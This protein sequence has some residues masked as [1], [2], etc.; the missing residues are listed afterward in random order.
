MKSLFN[1]FLTIFVSLACGLAIGYFLFQSPMELSSS[2]E[3]DKIPLYWVAPMDANFRRDKPGKSPM[4]MDLVPVYETVGGPGEVVISPEVVNNLGVRTVTVLNTNLQ[5]Q[6]KTVGYVQYDQDKL[7][8]IHPRVEGWV[9]KLY[10]K[11][12]G[13]PVQKN[14]PLYDLYS[15]ELVNAQEE[16]LLAL[17][18]NN[19]Q[20]IQSA[21]LRLKALHIPD[22]V[23]THINKTRKV[24]QTVTFYAP[25]AGYSDNLKIREG[26][27]VTPGT[28]L[29]SI[30]NL[31]NV[32][33]EAE[34]FERQAAQVKVGLA[35]TMTLDYLPGR[36]WVGAVDYVYPA[37]NPQNRT[38]RVRLRFDNAEKILKPNMFAQ[39]IIHAE[40]NDMKLVVPNEAVIRT[41]SQ[42]RVVLA[43]EQGRFKS[44]AVKLGASDDVHTQVLEGLQQGDVIVSSAQFL[45]D[46][47]SSKTSDFMR[48][49]SHTE[50][51]ASV[52][53]EAR[54]EEVMVDMGMV[55]LT[56]QPIEEWDWPVMTMMFPVNDSVDIGKLKEGLTLHVE[57]SETD[58]TWVLS[59]IHSMEEMKHD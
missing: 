31:E 12:S 35:V 17:N 51:P 43:L 32:W 52:W 44:I 39:V 50:K 14:Q 5:P 19:S 11:T 38:V 15:P 59:G 56:H 41:G 8:H 18:R 57:I 3:K 7:V 25:Q 2:L 27:Y 36:E 6:I 10:I 20:F 33:V 23:V 26:F 49:Q 30:A 47:E 16:Y 28:T 1:R 37:L 34:I 4:G 9:E 29:M 24:K 22:A 45:L 48:M 40:S 58:D 54:I 21:Q 55:K 53:V 42:N 13:D 46:S